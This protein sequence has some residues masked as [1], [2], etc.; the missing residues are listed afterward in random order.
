MLLKGCHSQKCFFLVEFFICMYFFIS[1]QNFCTY[2]NELCKEII[3]LY[4]WGGHQV[5]QL[6]VLFIILANNIYKKISD[7]KNC[8]TLVK[9][10]SSTGHP[11]RNTRANDQSLHIPYLLI[12]HRSLEFFITV[13][14]DREEKELMKALET[15]EEKRAR[16]LAKKVLW[17]LLEF[18]ILDYMMKM[19]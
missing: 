18:L 3:T 6:T 10:C 7:F 4:G 14:F 12:F 9:N 15:P 11:C 2:T 13:F 5:C 17:P 8:D 1:S 19:F 16:R